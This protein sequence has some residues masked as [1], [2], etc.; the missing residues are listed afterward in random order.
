MIEK[1]GVTHLFAND[2]LSYVVTTLGTI[3]GTIMFAVIFRWGLQKVN[4]QH[5]KDKTG[6]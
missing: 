3:T 1:A 4:K 2:V 5:L 6:E